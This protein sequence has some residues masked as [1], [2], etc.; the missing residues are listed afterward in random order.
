MQ[1]RRQNLIK[2][3]Y[4]RRQLP[5]PPSLKRF[6]AGDF[7]DCGGR[8]DPRVVRCRSRDLDHPHRQRW[9]YV[10]CRR[11]LCAYVRQDVAETDVRLRPQSAAPLSPCTQHTLRSYLQTWQWARLSGLSVGAWSRSLYTGSFHG[12]MFTR[13]PISQFSTSRA[14]RP[15]GAKAGGWAHSA[16]AAP[17]RRV[18]ALAWLAAR[19]VGVISMASSH[20]SAN[21]FSTPPGLR[22][23]A[24]ESPPATFG[25]PRVAGGR[26]AQRERAGAAVL[27][28]AGV[29]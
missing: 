25:Q 24:G 16:S 15:V 13:R 19:A 5:H 18:I 20:I 23:V 2:V 8:D 3:H 28:S 9:S 11:R 17:L 29:G 22:F 4:L 6:G 7:V 10:V 21:L 26:R 27:P 12:Q 1:T 14:R